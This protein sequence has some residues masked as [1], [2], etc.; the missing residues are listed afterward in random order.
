MM[1]ETLSRRF[2]ERTRW[3]TRKSLRSRSCLGGCGR[4]W[5]GWEGKGWQK[6][7]RTYKVKIAT[8]NGD[9]KKVQSSQ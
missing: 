6:K 4:E 5:E 9:H 8:T 2:L 7:N 3:V 1:S